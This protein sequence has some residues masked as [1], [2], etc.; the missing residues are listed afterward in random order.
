MIGWILE[1]AG[2]DPT[3][4]NGA[5]MKNFVTDDVPFA[6][7]RVGSAGGGG[8]FVSEVDESDGSIALF[9]PRIAVVGNISL[10]HKPLAELRPLFSTFARKARA[11]VLNFDNAETRALAAAMPAGAVATFGLAAGAERGA[12]VFARDVVPAPDGVRFTVVE[13][14]SGA[15]A[16]LR[17]AMPGSHNVANALAAIAAAGE[18]GV[19]LG[20]AAAA[21]ESF[22]GLKRRF[23]RIGVA[24]GVAVIDDFAHNPD[25]I[26]AILGALRHFPGRL[27]VMF[28][29][30]G[31]GPLKLMREALVDCFADRLA[32]K[33]VLVM[34]EPVYFGGTADRAVTSADIARAVAA[35]GRSAHA[36]PDRK[37]CGEALLA[38]ARPGD[39][40]VIMGARDDTLAE[41][42]GEMVQKLKRR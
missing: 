19:T 30:H 3:I 8:A 25:K 6:S 13:R 40:I 24:G 7:A 5:V 18:A 33:D 22:A 34:P 41:F 35:K 2:R 28:Q 32:A 20:A 38:V 26:A 21:L 29:P 42:A 10:D 1:R 14:G 31:Y 36:F 17:L 9:D 16:A 11:A 23:E 4:M 27:L 39:R 37:A 15:E 12:D